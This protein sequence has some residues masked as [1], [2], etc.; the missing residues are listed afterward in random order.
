MS[1][2]TRFVV[3]GAALGIVVGGGLFIAVGALHLTG[4]SGLL[5]RFAGAGYDVTAIY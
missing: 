2:R 1:F 5:E 3:V 4:E